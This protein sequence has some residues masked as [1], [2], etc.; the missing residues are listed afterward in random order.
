MGRIVSVVAVLLLAGGCA[1][2]TTS[3]YDASEVGRPIE[4][5]PATVVSARTVQ[6][7]GSGDQAMIGPAIGA[8]AGAAGTGLGYHGRGSGW[9]AVLGGLVGAG[10]GYAIQSALNE[11]EGIEYLLRMNDGRVITVVQNRERQEVPLVPGTAV[12][13][14]TSG[15]YSRVLPDPSALTMAPTALNVGPT[16]PAGG[17]ASPVERPA[18]E[19]TTN[20]P[21]LLAPANS[22][23]WRRP[24]APAT[25]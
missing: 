8:A 20:A 16:A 12:L 2:E 14:Q 17:V 13:V 1:H 11:R 4:V 10:A 3:S 21:T 15:G 24:P 18:A 5:T 19:A 9:A 6:V 7:T 22:Q 25:P 23:S